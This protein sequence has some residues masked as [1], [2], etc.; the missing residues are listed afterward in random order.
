MKIIEN[1]SKM[2]KNSKIEQKASLISLQIVH[3]FPNPDNYTSPTE[4]NF[5][6]CFQIILGSRSVNSF[7]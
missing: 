7:K 1:K 2:S 5:L 6:Q 3:E 4:M